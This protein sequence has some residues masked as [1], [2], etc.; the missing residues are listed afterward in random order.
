MLPKIGFCVSL[1]IGAV[2]VHAAENPHASDLPNESEIRNLLAERI[3]ALGGEQGGVGIVVGV[4]A[5]EGQHIASAGRR[6]SDD[7][8]APNGNT[9]FEIGSVTKVFTAL[10]LTQMAQKSEVGLN[11]PVAKYLPARLKVPERHGKT[12]SLLDL[13]THR[14]GLPFMPNE[15]ATSSNSEANKYSV[16]D[17]RRFIANCELRSDSGQKWEYSNIG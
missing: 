10:L 13:A 8:R 5:P 17:L 4:I 1:I 11:D 7:S 6:S 14:S 3:E 2:A 16:A 12:I 9:V 15:S